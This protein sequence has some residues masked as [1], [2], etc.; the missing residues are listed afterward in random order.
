MGFFD[1]LKKN[2]APPKGNQVQ[3]KFTTT[4]YFE[5]PHQEYDP[6]ERKVMPRND[7]YAIAGFISYCQYGG[8]PIGKTND[9]Y[10]RYFSYRYYVNDP[11]KYHKK[12]IA[13]GYLTEAE[14]IA[15]LA[16]LKVAQLKE[17]LASH[18][19]LDKGRKDA[20][21]A[22][23][24]ENIDIKTL[25]LETVYVP[26]EK[27]LAHLEKYAYMFEIEKYDISIDEFERARKHFHSSSTPRDIIWRI[28]D[29][30][31]NSLN[32][33]GDYGLA[34]NVLCNMAEFS[35]EENNLT[36]AL[37]C[38][39]LV[40][41]Y[42]TSGCGN[43]RYIEKLDNVSI[44]PGIIERIFDLKEYYSDQ[45]IE[46]CYRH[47]LPHHYLKQANFEKLIQDIFEDNPIDIKKY[48]K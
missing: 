25:N 6:W 46:K 27:G 30:K 11:I 18:G 12:V 16:S 26:T 19:L 20:L 24:A 21:I 5:T 28:L 31:R 17:I 3:I 35:K 4:N 45:M 33:M 36:S 34:R 44:A 22:R 7:N 15:L 38:Y 10:P 23:I 43:N 41:Y 39:L 1:F 47:S 14:P 2:S 37:Y 13:D 9:D 8:K 48:V 42:D 32:N 40:I 29:A